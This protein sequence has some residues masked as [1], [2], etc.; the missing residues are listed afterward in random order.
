LELRVLGCSGGSARGHHPTS[1]L[2]D[3]HIAIDA[4]AVT[5]NLSPLEQERVDHVVLSHAHL[6]HIAN[7][8][9]LLD[10]RFARQTKPIR[11]YGPDATLRDLRTDVFNNRVWPDFTNLHNRKSVALETQSIAAG[12]AFDVE[13]LRFSPDAMLHPVECYGYKIAAGDHAI[14][15]AGDTGSAEPVKRA[16]FGDPRIKAIVIEVS[17]PDRMA[18]LAEISGHL[19]PKTLIRHWPLHPTARVLVSHIKPFYLDEVSAELAALGLA[20]IEI[21]RD[22][23]SFQF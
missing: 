15:I 23:M 4:G 18:A 7:L 10:N 6:D 22:G 11:I 17:W 14:Y 21:L 5:A 8:P 1:F 20:G 3:D 19:V 16:V 13:N 2:I 12:V 9:F